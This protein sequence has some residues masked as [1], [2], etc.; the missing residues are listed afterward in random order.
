MFRSRSAVS[1]TVQVC[2]GLRDIGDAQFK[3][4][5]SPVQFSVLRQARTEPRGI[6]KAR[7][8]FDDHF[9]PNGQY[10][11][12]ACDSP[13]YTSEMKFDCGCGWPGFWTNIKD[14]VAERPDEDGSG[15][16]EILCSAC[17]SHLGHVFRGEGFS[18]PEPNERH[19]VNSVSLKFKRKDGSIINCTYNGPTY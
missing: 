12:A 10:L 11:C 19:C 16:S 6:T 1:A 18:N 15:R 3:K 13:L 8:G 9:E 17:R 5:L 7:G 14:A 4:K 2:S